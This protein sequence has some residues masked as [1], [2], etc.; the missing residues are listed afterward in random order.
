MFFGMG[1]LWFFEDSQRNK[2]QSGFLGHSQLKKKKVNWLA[3]CH[4][5]KEKKNPYPQIY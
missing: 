3:V 1:M 5:V 4:K 2:A